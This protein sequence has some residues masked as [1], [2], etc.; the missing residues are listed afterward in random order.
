M[1]FSDAST[2]TERLQQLQM[3]FWRNPRQQFR[4]REIAERL[5]VTEDTVTRYLDELSVD[6]R[7]PVRK[8]GWYWKL[9]EDAHFDLLPVKLNLAEGAALYLAA[10]LLSQIHDER[11]EHIL[12]ALTKL[13]AGMPETIAPHQHATV[14][15]ARE[16]QKGQQDKSSVFGALALGWATRRQVRLVYTP[17][18]L[19]TYTCLFSPYLLEPSPVGRTIYAL[20]W[21]NPPDALRTYKMERIEH[22]ELLESTFEIPEDFNG[23]ALLKRAWGVMYGEEEPIKVHLRFSHWVTKRVKETLWHPTQEI[24][25]TPDGC[26]WS[27]QIGDSVEIANWIRG[28]GSDCEVLAPQ[29]LREEMA[30]EARRLAHLYDV[31]P[32]TP[33]SST[34]EPDMD[35]FDKM[36]GG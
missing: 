18:R 10:R 3:L 6:G 34:D 16:R 26:E 32:Q 22:A 2:K 17:P 31:V 11:N 21:S 14:E 25:E 19:K 8:E 12:Q 9:A 28:W 33:A 7:L 29:T 36:Y 20:G 4:T 23:P 24:K 1:P 35:F 5:N 27:A 15:M 30:K 13:I